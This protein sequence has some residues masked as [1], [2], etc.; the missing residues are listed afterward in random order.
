MLCA[1]YSSAIA[2]KTSQEDHLLSHLNVLAGEGWKS[3][4]TAGLRWRRLV[5]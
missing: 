1:K 2:T 3:G 4:M 5:A